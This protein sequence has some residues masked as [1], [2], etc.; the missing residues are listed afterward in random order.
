M[1]TS[2]QQ[3]HPG[4]DPHLWQSSKCHQKG[5]LET[6]G[7]VPRSWEVPLG[8]GRGPK[9]EHGL[10]GEDWG[11]NGAKIELRRKAGDWR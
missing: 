3:Q 9:E 6:H 4:Y 11:Y 7:G 5:T 10:V 8:L 1:C 2:H